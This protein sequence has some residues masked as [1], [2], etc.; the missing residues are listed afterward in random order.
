MPDSARVLH[1]LMLDLGF[2]WYI[3]HGGDVGSFLA[4]TMAVGFEQCVALHCKLSGI[5]LA[6]RR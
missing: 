6:E 5:F 4:T 2:K 3:A 1:T